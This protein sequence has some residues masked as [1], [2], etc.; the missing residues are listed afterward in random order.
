MPATGVPADADDKASL[1][2]SLM[3]GRRMLIV[4][5]DAVSPKQARPL[6]PS[7]P[8]SLVLITSRTQLS[9]LVAAEAARPLVLD[10]LTRDEAYE[11]LVARLGPD[12]LS[13]EPTA[14][15][16]VIGKC[17]GLPLALTIA[18]SSL[19]SDPRAGLPGLATELGSRRQLYQPVVLDPDCKRQ[20]AREANSF[21]TWDRHYP[22][23]DGCY[24][25]CRRVPGASQPSHLMPDTPRGLPDI[26]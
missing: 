15:A 4:L 3:D 24:G 25:L 9:G 17:A 6:L 13:A 22:E 8:G 26:I 14:A 20:A 18:A 16:E 5:D 1:Y 7:A 2:R 11:L 21:G 23:R 10:P 19:A 12:R